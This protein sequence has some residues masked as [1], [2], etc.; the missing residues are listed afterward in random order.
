MVNPDPRLVEEIIEVASRNNQKNGV[1]GMLLYADGNV[2][3]VLEG[4]QA[5]VMDTFGRILVDM[6]HASIFVLYEREISKRDFE[7]WSM[8]Y[9]PLTK[10]DSERLEATRHV[11]QLSDQEVTRRVEPSDALEILKSF[12]KTS[13]N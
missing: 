4:E 3:Q 12:T 13:A 10:A 1:T 7:S 5:S 2:V 9:Q 11:F 6:R 8:G